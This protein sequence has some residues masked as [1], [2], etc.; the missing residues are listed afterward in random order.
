V[1][2][3][4]ELSVSRRLTAKRAL[5]LGLMT[6]DSGSFQS[7]A[8][9]TRLEVARAVMLGAGAHVPQYLPYSPSFTD[10]EGDSNAI[11]VESVTHSPKGD[12][13][14]TSG[15]QF[16]PHA[17]ADRLTVAIAVVKALGLDSDAQAAG[18]GDPG[19]SDWNAIPAAA[20]GYVSV[21]VTHG[22]MGA[23]SSSC[24]RPFDSITRGELATAAIAL[25]Q[26][27]R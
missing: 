13:M 15:S 16:N 8:A 10:V 1:S 6:A 19:L 11:F 7:N 3:L 23:N 25:Q 12:L 22:L 5:L 18:A 27:A 26:A 20:R 4:D 21:A 9:A 2:G 14:G 24:F 17:S